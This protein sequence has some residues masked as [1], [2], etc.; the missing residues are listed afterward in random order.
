M[1]QTTDHPAAARGVPSTLRVALLDDY[2]RIAT[3]LADWSA[4]PA[5]SQVVS[6]S[7]PARDADELVARLCGYDVVVAMR[8]RSAFPAAVLERLPRLALLVSTGGTRNGAIDVAACRRLGITACAAPGHASGLAATAET[9]WALVL[10]LAKRVVSSDA[11]LR[12]GAWQPQLA[13]VLAGRTL[14]IVGL[15]RLGQRMA[16]IGA[17]FGMEA[18]AWS[19]HLTPER[20]TA[21]GAR[22]VDKRALFEQADVVTLHMVL[23][24]STAGLVSG[25]ELA[26]MKPG[27]VLVNTARAGLVDEAALVAALRDGRIAGAG[28]DVFWQEP[29]PGGH[30]LVGM[31]NVVLTPHLG[32][33]THENIGAFYVSAAQAVRDWAAGGQ[34]TLLEG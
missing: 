26:A 32:Y 22:A 4:L 6:I 27:A 28:L 33:A 25:A 10:A 30:P 15:G 12:R 29:L 18:I 21:A 14:G 31:D 3:G 24:P 20:A 16:R 11:A 2:Q 23:S 34:T 13:G 5:G 9:A 7:E 8:E 17:A 19:P 1:S